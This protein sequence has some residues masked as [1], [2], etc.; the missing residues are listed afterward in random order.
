MDILNVNANFYITTKPSKLQP[1]RINFDNTWNGKINTWN[2]KIRITMTGTQ[3]KNIVSESMI[4]QLLRQHK[5]ID[6]ALDGSY[7]PT[8]GKMA[9]GWL[10]AIGETII[11]TGKGPAEGEPTLALAFR[12][13]AFG[14]KSAAQFL[15]LMIDHFN[16]TTP[17][18]YKWFIHIDNKALIARMDLYQTWR[19]TPKSTQWPDAD[20]TIPAYN[21]LVDINAQFQHIKSHS[22]KENSTSFPSRLH[23]M[24][25]E[26]AWAFRNTMKTPQRQVTDKFCLL[27]VGDQ[28]VTRDIQRIIIETSSKI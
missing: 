7:D 24:A 28:F 27:R 11:A 18:N 4:E 6:A 14:L 1:T 8:N 12:A 22:T 10:V 16:I 5:L 21:H 23:N 19:I 25:D 3:I 2:G 20:V 15:R 17:S 13:E 9:F 26:L